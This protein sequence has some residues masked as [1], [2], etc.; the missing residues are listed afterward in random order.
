MQGKPAQSDVDQASARGAD[1]AWLRRL[2]FLAILS[3]A[4][5]GAVLLRDQLDFDALARHQADLLGYRDAHY[6]V[7][8]LGFILIYVA[9][10]G[11]SLP[12][13]TVATLAGGYLFGVFPGVVFNVGSAGTGAI[14][15]FLAA[16]AGFGSGRFR[17]EWPRAAVRWRGCRSG[18]VRNEWSVLFLMRL[19][20]VIPFFLAN[21]LPAAIGTSLWR[22]A[23][24]TFLG[25]FPATLVFT[26][27]GAGLGEV[28]ARG[29]RPDFGLLLE[30]QI[31]IPILGLALI[32]A[33]PMVLKAVRKEA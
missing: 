28:F 11:L 14:L 3:T 24:T 26:A 7:T 9:I 12:G 29:E 10:V 16:R 32:A 23:V 13:A 21:L 33:L 19:L 4:V 20:P 27:V 1:R 25:I 5:L 31:M 17:T 8:V 15:V 6:L 18:L 2:P 22:F 30:P